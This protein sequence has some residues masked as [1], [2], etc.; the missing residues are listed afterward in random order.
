MPTKTNRKH[1]VKYKR[2]SIERQSSIPEVGLD[3]EEQIRN[4]FGKSKPKTPLRLVE[5]LACPVCEKGKLVLAHDLTVDWAQN[6]ERIVVGNLTGFRCTNCGREF[7]DAEG[8]RIISRYIDRSR[9]RG[10][11]TAKISSLGG[12]KLGVYF[13]QDLLRN[14]D[15]SKSDH[16]QLYP[17]SRRKI[18]IEGA[19]PPSQ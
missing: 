7:F 15:L 10:G 17:I 9:P 5:G 13:P 6:G 14:I 4:R 8:A 12:G 19:E 18:V 2:N 11:Y 3:R 16:V 1:R